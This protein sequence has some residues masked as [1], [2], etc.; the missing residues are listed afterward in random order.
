MRDVYL[1][2]HLV[3]VDSPSECGKTTLCLHLA[4]KYRFNYYH[5]KRWNVPIEEYEKD[6]LD[7][8]FDNI[9]KWE[10]NFVIERLYLSEEAYANMYNYTSPYKD[11]R[12]FDAYLRDRS[13]QLGV[14]YSLITCLPPKEDANIQSE[15][16]NILYDEFN[17][18]YLNNRDLIYKYDFTRDPN[19]YEI[20]QYLESK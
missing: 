1:K 17:K 5:I 19:Y 16:E 4:A 11:W 8:A 14:K 15:K 3:I 13:E 18:I 9:K 12:Q 7:F 6:I 2:K 20:D 10:S